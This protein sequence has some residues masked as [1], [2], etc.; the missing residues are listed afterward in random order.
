MGRRNLKEQRKGGIL[1][2]GI[3]SLVSFDLRLRSLML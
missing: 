1:E 3:N 2:L